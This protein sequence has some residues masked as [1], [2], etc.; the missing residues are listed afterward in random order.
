[1]KTNVL[2]HYT[3]RYFNKKEIRYAA[4]KNPK[5]NFAIRIGKRYEVTQIDKLRKKIVPH[6]KKEISKLNKLIDFLR[7]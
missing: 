2:K 4:N 3:D 5:P 1:M 6:F 7:P